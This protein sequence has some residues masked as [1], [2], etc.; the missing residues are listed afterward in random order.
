MLKKLF[1][2]N[3]GFIIPLRLLGIARPTI[4]GSKDLNF[5][6]IFFQISI[7]QFCSALIYVVAHRYMLDI[8]E[9]CKTKCQYFFWSLDSYF[10]WLMQKIIYF[11]KRGGGTVKKLLQSKLPP[12][13][14]SAKY[15]L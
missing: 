12:Y 11:K 2:N 14:N 9:K 15:T 1:K 5:L 6:L 4:K 10:C 7:E 13:A 3:F 8:P